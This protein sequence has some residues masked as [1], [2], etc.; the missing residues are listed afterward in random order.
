MSIKWFSR[1]SF[2]YLFH[3]CKRHRYKLSF[4]PFLF[5][6][7]RKMT[8]IP[9]KYYRTQ[10]TFFTAS[11]LSALTSAAVMFS[12]KNHGVHDDEL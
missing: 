1:W 11:V 12:W 10:S 8:Q 7:N 6:N 4:S 3:E 9:L 5:L 2:K